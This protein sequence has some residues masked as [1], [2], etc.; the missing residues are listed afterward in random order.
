MVWRKYAWKH[1]VAARRKHIEDL[2]RQLGLGTRTENAIRVCRLHI[3]QGLDKPQDV[4]V[5]ARDRYDRTQDGWRSPISRR[6][7][8]VSYR[9]YCE[10]F[11]IVLEA[12]R[13][14]TLDLL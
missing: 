9:E 5:S 10:W 8:G 2:R 11:P 7:H 6:R 12:K 1:S 13:R 3:K 4:L 14:G